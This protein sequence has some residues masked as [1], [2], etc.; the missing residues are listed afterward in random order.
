MNDSSVK[1]INFFRPRLFGRIEH[2]RHLFLCTLPQLIH[3][4]LDLAV[5]GI[6]NGSDNLKF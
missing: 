3:V 5:S 4:S 6:L 1:V 2:V